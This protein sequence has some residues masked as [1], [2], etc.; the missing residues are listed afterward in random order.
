[1]SDSCPRAA[2]GIT[3]TAKRRSPHPKRIFNKSSEGR[4]DHSGFIVHPFNPQTLGP[5]NLKGMARQKK[6]HCFSYSINISIEKKRK[7]IEAG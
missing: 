1:M 7:E 4:M 3:R 6:I 2:E 5:R